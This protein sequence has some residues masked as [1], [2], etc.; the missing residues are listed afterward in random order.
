MIEPQSGLFD[1]LGGG[2]DILDGQR[3]DDTL[4]GG[5]GADQFVFSKNSGDDVILGFRNGEDTMFIKNGANSFDDLS[6]SQSGGRTLIEFAGASIQLNGVSQ[7]QL[8][9]TDFLFG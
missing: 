2:D 8:D 1:D 3:G 5:A 9:E 6:I 4:K 7:N